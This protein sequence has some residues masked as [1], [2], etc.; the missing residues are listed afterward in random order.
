[1]S[2]ELTNSTDT[3]TGTGISTKKI[4][5]P[6][7]SCF[8]ML[9][10]SAKRFV[11]LIVQKSSFHFVWLLSSTGKCQFIVCYYFSKLQLLFIVT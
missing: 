3:H 2:Y 7:F 6:A 8:I 1:M 9:C 4:K 11:N 10:C 5:K